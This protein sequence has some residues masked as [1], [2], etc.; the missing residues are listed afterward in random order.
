MLLL[1]VEVAERLLVGEQELPVGEQEMPKVID[2]FAVIAAAAAAAEQVE[3]SVL[4]I[5]RQ[6]SAKS[7]KTLFGHNSKPSANKAPECYQPLFSTRA[8]Y[9]QSRTHASPNMAEQTYHTHM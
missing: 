3:F 8:N 4:V 9:D 2:G 6:H 7:Q 1:A 5:A